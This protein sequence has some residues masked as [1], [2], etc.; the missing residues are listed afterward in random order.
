MFEICLHNRC[1][2]MPM[3]EEFYAESQAVEI[4]QTSLRAAGVFIYLSC[5]MPVI[6]IFSFS[7]FFFISP[8]FF[9][10]SLGASEVDVASGNSRS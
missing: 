3:E 8:S 10:P 6:E 1:P 5:L 9:P 4:V 7:S 2:G